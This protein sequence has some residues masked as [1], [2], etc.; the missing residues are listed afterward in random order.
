MRRALPWIVAG[1]IAVLA[2]AWFAPILV[3]P[4]AGVRQ[5]H[6]DANVPERTSFATFMARDL[7]S[8]FQ[9]Q[10]NG[11]VQVTYE[12]LRKDPTQ[13]GAAYPKFYVWVVVKRTGTP[14][15]TGAARVEAVDKRG[16]SVTRFI[17]AAEIRGD[18]DSVRAVFPA[19]LVA[20]I[21][22]HAREAYEP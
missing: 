1:G 11:P 8:H 3:D 22:R 6:I 2:I 16:F 10:A 13:S 20:D 5:S 17:S 4:L 18:P 21:Q 9:A 19:A 7:S 12:L 15:Q 14:W